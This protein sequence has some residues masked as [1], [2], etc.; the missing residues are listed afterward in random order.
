MTETILVLDPINDGLLARLQPLMPPHMTLVRATERGDAHL[1]EIIA[2]ADYAITGQIGV[3]AAVFQAAKKLK[4]MHKWGV[5]TDNIDIEAAR[6]AGITV[7]RTTGSNARAVAEFSL[8]LMLSALRCIPYGH[9]KL[10]QGVWVGV[11]LPM[12]T[13]L[14]S[15]KTVGII[16]FGM[17]GQRLAQILAGF[18]CTILYNKRTPLPAEQEAALGARHASVEEIL[19]TCDVVSLNCPLTEQTKDMIDLVALRTMKK[20]AVLV[21]CARG[22]VVVEKDLVVA[23]K[24][25]VIQ[26]AAMDVFE[27]EPLP[28]DS[29]LL[30]IDNLV[31]TPHLA[32][33]AVDL[34]EPTINQMVGNILRVSR[35]EKVAEQ[36]FVV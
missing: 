15:G 10:R 26:A 16:G 1:C 33:M 21:N 13:N 6:A 24:E 11:N 32:A 23:L 36:D 9:E 31:V 29:P 7:A 4:L 17:I 22:G 30:G 3:S 25:R 8:G 14:L 35:G 20:T 12:P 18:G 28:P 34:F 5:G 19:T 27:M 2:D